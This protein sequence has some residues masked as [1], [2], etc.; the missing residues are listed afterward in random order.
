MVADKTKGLESV[1][2]TIIK[3]SF[4]YSFHGDRLMLSH[5]KKLWAVLASG[6]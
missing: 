4:H 2:F 5:L 3:W 6:F 1:G